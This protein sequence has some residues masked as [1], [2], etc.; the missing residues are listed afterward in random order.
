[1]IHLALQTEYSFK[2][3]FLHMSDIHKYVVDGYV[4]IA[5]LN[6]TFG[7]IPLS[8]EAKKHGFKPIYGVRLH[9]AEN[10]SKLRTCQVSWVFIAKNDAGLKEIY[11][12]VEKAHKQFYFYPKLFKSDLD[13]V[14]PNVFIVQ[15]FFEKGMVS[16]YYAVGQGYESNF[17]QSTKCLAIDQNSYGEIGDKDVYQLLAG[18]RKN[19]SSYSYFYEEQTYPQHIL[20]REDWLCEFKTDLA[21]RKTFSV[22]EQCDAKIPEAEMVK[23]D[24]EKNID[25]FLDFDKVQVWTDEYEERY[26]YEMN[27]IKE[28]DYGDYFLIVADMIKE[29]K[30]TMLVGPARGSSAG[31]L[32]CYLLDITEVD[33]IEHGLIFERFI[34]INRH[35]L[36]DI[37]IDFPDTKRAQVIEYLKDRYGRD[38]VMCLANINRLKGKSAIGEFA[39]GFG[40]PA[41]E[42]TGLKDSLIER[43]GGDSRAN[44]CI[45]DT[46]KETE[47]GQLFISEYPKMGLVTKVEGHVSHS[48]K[49]AAGILVSTLPL[50]NYGSLNPRDEIIQLDKRDAEHL[51]LLKIDCLGLKNLT[52]LEGVADQIGVDYDFF[53]N[54]PL[55]DKETYKLFNSGRLSGI[56]QFEGQSLQQI[57]KQMGVKDFGD[58]TAITALARPGALSSGGAARFVKYSTGVEEPTY[59]SDIHR[60]ITGDTFGIVVYQEQMMEM[61]RQI[62][63][64]SWEDV[65]TLRKATSKSM[66]EEFI[67][68]YRDAFIE[69]AIKNGYSES[70][71]DELWAD[72]ASS[73]SYSFNKS[74]AVG[75]GLVSYWV[76]WCKANYPMEFAVACLNSLSDPNSASKLLR[77]M[78]RNEGFQYSSVD[79][80]LSEENWSTHN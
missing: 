75:Y 20:N 13:D 70:D 80:N 17:Y 32:I 19:G 15:P 40:I 77:D 24:G 74:H 60:D 18:A 6:N 59:Y 33:P 8:I 1:M 65:S 14:S 46:F 36:P 62:G 57:V 68:K 69:G 4:G 56:F 2:K 42:T 58:I 39:K 11:A 72:I 78:V 47:S 61:A 43:S 63:G 23:W 29:A 73:G 7:H 50:C 5:D 35:D 31:S 54:L 34:D 66:G 45:E 48:G 25:K 22:A 76:A 49:H 51:G 21:I 30:K 16:D 55:D 52:I 27:L 67:A 9:V 28:K 44:Q 79:I 3:C 10:D 38:K 64:L 71:S 41:Y 26:T 12:L 53:Y 37:D